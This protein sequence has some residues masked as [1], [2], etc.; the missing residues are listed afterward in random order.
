MDSF[1]DIY[2]QHRLEV[3]RY[4]YFL[5]GDAQFAEDL[6]QETF[7]Q[8]FLSLWRFRGESSITTWIMAIARRVYLK[9]QRRGKRFSRGRPDWEGM[10]APDQEAPEAVLGRKER[11]EEIRETLRL[12][13]EEYRSVLIWREI[14]ELS[15]A[16]IGAI[17]GK[18]PATVRVVLFR[19]RKRFRELFTGHYE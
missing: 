15:F 19:A 18:S 17:L 6:T 7:L 3:F 14:E 2:E 12:L 10:A 16:E 4:L 11:W 9:H 5:S 13:P 1:G 8:A